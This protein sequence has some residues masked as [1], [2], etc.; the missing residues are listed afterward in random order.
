MESL[1]VHV[2]AQSYGLVHKHSELTFK[3]LLSASRKMLLYHLH[4]LILSISHFPIKIIKSLQ[5]T[6]IVS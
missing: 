6:L 2:D 5:M 4:L 1:F 3:C